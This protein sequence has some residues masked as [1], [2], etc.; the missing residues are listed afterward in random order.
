MSRLLSTPTR[1]LAAAGLVL[2][3]TAGP[4]AA[5]G[6]ADV[7]DLGPASL[8]SAIVTGALAGD[9]A[10]VVSRGIT[11]ANLGVLDRAT[12]TVTTHPLPASQGA[13]ASAVSGGQMYVA[14]YLPPVVYRVGP[15]GSHTQVAAPTSL[16]Y[17]YDLT[18]APDGLLVGGGYPNGH[19]YTID[20]ATSAVRDLG[21]AY[22]G[23][24]YVRSVAAD[25]TTIYVGVGSHAHLM[26]I[27]RAGGAKSDILPA[28]LRDD[29]FVY[30]LATNDTYVV[31]AM[32]PSGRVAII[33]KHDP[34]NFR[35][36]QPAPGVVG[37]ADAVT[38]AGG[39]AYVTVRPTA[40]VFQLDLAS[41]AV[42]SLGQA[43]PGEE[44][45]NLYV[46]D[47]EL[48]GFSGSGIMWTKPLPTGDFGVLDLQ[49]A[50][51]TPGAELPLSVLTNGSTVLVG[52]NFGAQ[53][54]DLA[55]GTSR[56][57]R[58]GGEIKTGVAAGKTAYVA[59]YPTGS[60]DTVD[61]RTGAVRN[62]STLGHAQIR[63]RDL[64]RSDGKV[65]VGTQPDYGQFGGALSIVDERTGTTEVYRDVVP[66]QSVS[67]VAVA[68]GVAYLGSEIYGGLG[69]TPRAT[70]AV[71]S[72]F[73][74][75][76]RKV[77][78]T[79]VPVPGA[80]RIQDLVVVG[81]RLV[82]VT[83]T[84]VLFE[85]DRATGQ[86]TRTAK[87]STAG[88]QLQVAGHQLTFVDGNQVL[89]IDAAGWQTTT[90]ATGLKSSVAGEAQGALDNRA[91]Y[92]YTIRQTNLVRV[93]VR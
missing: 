47:G 12:G 86:V 67:A 20:P 19:T 35:I 61:L 50:G 69:T 66:D 3:A 9:Q 21:Q 88:G 76:S 63:P 17:F 70:E 59:V 43:T 27:D 81:H 84:G 11:P 80:P 32:V 44:T 25:D 93:P 55:D 65:Y 36:V 42:R 15:D 34:A 13:W 26:A 37:G 91:G 71:L 1:L 75:A 18:A 40:E 90:L 31:A 54:H 51:L 7:V 23:E 72:F 6:T 4:A 77:S 10:Y 45:R 78:R 92:L 83:S 24:Q 56:R 16:Q 62:L 49:Q 14:T 41:G 38:V 57:I 5:T 22:P 53:L 39:S 87:V 73:D 28:A 79:L 48:I 74:V 64:T 52:G 29:S 2:A 8:S 89:R 46:E 33:D 82:G 85:V 60:V 68:G 30:D 58:I